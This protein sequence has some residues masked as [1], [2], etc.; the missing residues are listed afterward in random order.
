M[1]MVMAEA[2]ATA[3]V[4]EAMAMEVRPMA[5]PRRIHSLHLLQKVRRSKR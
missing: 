5:T 4:A 1:A 3:M 2:T